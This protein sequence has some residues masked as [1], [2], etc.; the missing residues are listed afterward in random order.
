MFCLALAGLVL[1]APMVNGAEL[2]VN[3][4]AASHATV[5]LDTHIRRICRES[6]SV[7]PLMQYSLAGNRYLV[8]LTRAGS[9]PKPLGYCGSGYEDHLV[10]GTI[11][12]GQLRFKDRLLI[13]SCTKRLSLESDQGD[14][15][16]D[17][18]VL[19]QEK[20]RI[21]FRWLGDADGRQRAVD[22][23]SGRLRLI[24]LPATP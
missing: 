8:F 1:S 18:L 13:Q 3:P 19:D 10:L 9:V 15:P 6:E 23:S 11:V 21:G 20:Q 4:C 17:A 5:S 7:V 14:S 22:L 24:E 2:L 16:A 12:G